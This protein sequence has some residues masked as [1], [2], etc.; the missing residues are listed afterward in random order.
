M[1]IKLWGVRGSLPTPVSGDSIAAKIRKALSLARPGDIS[2]EESIDSFIRSLP[3]SVQSTFGGNTTSIQVVTGSGD[4]IIIDCGSGI[5]MLGHELMKGDF[6]EG[7]GTA[8]VLLSHTH[9]DHI[10]GIPF[11]LPFYVKGNRFNFYSAFPDLKKRLDYQ[12]AYTHFPVSF[13][14]LPAKKEFFTI[15]AEEELYVNDTKVVNK[16]M[17][18]PGAAYGYRIEDG[19]KVLAYTSDCE[20][21]INEIDHIENYRNFFSDA[22]V[23]VFDTQYTFEESID[24]LEFGHSSASMAI[25]IAGMFNVKRLI[26][27]HHEP[28]YNDE[29]LE[30]VLFN[31]KTYLSMNAGRVGDMRVDIAYEGMEIIL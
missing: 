15:E 9:W 19:G 18:H 30:S 6:G 31:A 28:N 8:T 23:V 25:D 4:L 22:D 12:Q 3:F 5:R 21:N 7:R 24:K 10:Q 17:P 13:D 11:F 1:R 27:F 16:L 20:F 29:K 26:L 14:F 2:S